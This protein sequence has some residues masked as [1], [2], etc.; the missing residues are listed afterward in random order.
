MKGKTGRNA[1]E[2]TTNSSKKDRSTQLQYHLEKLCWVHFWEEN[3]VLAQ[4]EPQEKLFA[5]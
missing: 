2:G 1:F 5:A 3:Q 4:Q